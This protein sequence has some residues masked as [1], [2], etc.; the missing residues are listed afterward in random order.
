MNKSELLAFAIYASV[1][2]VEAV[3]KEARKRLK[4]IKAAGVGFGPFP[5]A[6]DIDAKPDMTAI[7]PWI[8]TVRQPGSPREFKD[9]A[10]RN[11]LV[12]EVEKL[13]EFT[14]T[15][16]GRLNETLQNYHVH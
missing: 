10:I 6:T 7:L 5:V 8:R 15:L 11:R 12:F 2:E 13:G 1:E 9:K 3:L 16:Q 4:E 14:E